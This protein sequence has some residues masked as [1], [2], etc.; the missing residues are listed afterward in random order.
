MSTRKTKFVFD[1][2]PLPRHVG[3]LVLERNATAN[4]L[5]NP[6]SGDIIVNCDYALLI[7]W[8][9]W[10]EILEDETT[11]ACVSSQIEFKLLDTFEQG[12]IKT[13]ARY[14]G[15]RLPVEERTRIL[16]AGRPYDD[17]IL[18][19]ATGYSLFD[20]IAGTDETEFII[21]GVLTPPTQ[22]LA[23]WYTKSPTN[24]RA[25]AVIDLSLCNIE[26]EFIWG[27]TVR[28]KYLIEN[29]TFYRYDAAEKT[30]HFVG[31]D[32][33]KIDLEGMKFSDRERAPDYDAYPASEYALR[34]QVAPF[35]TLPIA[36]HYPYPASGEQ[37]SWKGFGVHDFYQRIY[38]LVFGSW[39]NDSEQCS[40]KFYCARIDPGYFISHTGSTGYDG[41][42]LYRTEME[43]ASP[44][45]NVTSKFNLA[46]YVPME[47]EFICLHQSFIDAT[48]QHTTSKNRRYDMP[49]AFYH[50]A[51]A[52]DALTKMAQSF[53]YWTRYSKQNGQT[54]VQHIP[55]SRTPKMLKIPPALRSTQVPFPK[56]DSVEVV[57]YQGFGDIFLS[58]RFRNVNNY[59][60]IGD[61]AKQIG[62]GKTVKLLE[63]GLSATWITF[64]W[65]NALGWYNGESPDV[66]SEPLFDPFHE[67]YPNTISKRAL[68][69]EQ[70]FGIFGNLRLAILNYDGNDAATHPF[71]STHAAEYVIAGT[72]A[73]QSILNE[74][75]GTN[76]DNPYPGL[77]LYAGTSADHGATVNT[78]PNQ[79]TYGLPFS[80][81][82]FRGCGAIA[83]PYG[84][85][86][87]DGSLNYVTCYSAAD[88]RAIFEMN[89]A[90]GKGADFRQLTLPTV[91]DYENEYGETG[92]EAFYPTLGVEL[93]RRTYIAV[94]TK[95][96][97]DTDTSEM[98]LKG[99]SPVLPAITPQPEPI[100]YATIFVTDQNKRLDE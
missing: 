16:D 6:G 2:L 73:D 48:T 21:Y 97:W 45:H 35:S 89:F 5:L 78:A 32:K 52:W 77:I 40:W 50:H 44:N 14:L 80:G 24:P 28:G 54:R 60:K 68:K 30:V 59:V 4:E 79:P 76:F 100:K 18:S 34:S 47:D 10:E 75:M 66:H 93:Y 13:D 87:P 36:D 74:D 27:E 94:R 83:V 67:P 51:N 62:L 82:Y 85:P 43:W 58:R 95:L 91:D 8:P 61:T 12:F 86:N 19:R 71:V 81:H 49:F 46:K 17:K 26:E 22:L 70:I 65:D 41:Q 20:L 1:G 57:P 96:M 11:G 99:L 69:R 33:N 55:K 42:Q 25:V 23:N 29:R 37:I 38:N 72:N 31:N 63:P 84:D 39:I 64:K 56:I 7:Q 92:D 3:K 90:L 9:S 53:G 15:G 88:A 98:D